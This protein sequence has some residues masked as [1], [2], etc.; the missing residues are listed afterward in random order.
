M[1]LDKELIAIL[2]CPK[3]QGDLVEQDLNGEESL[4]C[5]TCK[6]L[7]SIKDSIPVLLIEDAAPLS[8]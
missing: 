6:L 1:A 8:E 5:E 4:K 7:F 2:A 3:C